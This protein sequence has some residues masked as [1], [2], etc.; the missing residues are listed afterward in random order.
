MSITTWSSS[1]RRT[2][3]LLSP[4]MDPINFYPA[5]NQ[6][7]FRS[8]IPKSRVTHFK[9]CQGTQILNKQLVSLG[10]VSMI[11]PSKYSLRHI[12]PTATNLRLHP[13]E[14]FKIF[15]KC[16]AIRFLKSHICWATMLI[17]I[18]FWRLNC[19]CSLLRLN[20]SLS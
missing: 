8:R 3:L 10:K 16:P 12:S 19:R 17:R 18:W 20:S 5:S 9:G 14:A 1:L 2:T 11:E 13:T 4:L 15:R 6:I 7:K